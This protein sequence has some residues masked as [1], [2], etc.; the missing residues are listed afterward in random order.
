MSQD[1]KLTQ[2]VS[3]GGCAAK[4]SPIDL[5]TI[6]NKLPP[7]LSKELLVG[8][9]KG[10]DACVYRINEET[11]LVFTT[12]FISPLVD[13]AYDFGK[14][15]AANALSDVYAMG[16]TPLLALN[17]VC[18]D[19]RLEN[20]VL[21]NILLGASEICKQANTIICGGHTVKSPEIRYGLAVI[22]TVHPDRIITNAN[23]IADDLII[24]T[25]PIGTGVLCQAL[26]NGMLDDNITND[27]TKQLYTLNDKVSMIMQDN[28][29]KCATDIT[30]F[31]LVG[32]LHKLAL[33]SN[34]GA[35]I[36]LDSIPVLEKALEFI[37]DNIYSSIIN[38][39][40]AF[41]EPYLN[42]IHPAKKKNKLLF[43]PQTSGGI[44][45]TVPKTGLDILLKDF[46]NNNIDSWIIGSLNSDFAGRITV[47]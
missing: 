15:A 20:S 35:E 10:D 6:L 45:M 29:V 11:A 26:K 31:G 25:K 46:K 8:L 19:D 16:G 2:T 9:D 37:R 18:F 14:V 32:H 1:I 38:K 7:Q 24:I 12:D 22:G 41:V 44:L 36:N 33:A 34:C 17:I 42:I 5:Y 21:E 47:Y 40:K 43:D 3:C 23:G 27:L 39:N 13:D 4:V 28:N 30:G